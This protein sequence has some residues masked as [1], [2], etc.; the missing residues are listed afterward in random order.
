M[1][2]LSKPIRKSK[3]RK[4]RSM[5][6][7]SWPFAHLPDRCFLTCRQCDGCVHKLMTVK[8]ARVLMEFQDNA[9][10]QGKSRETRFFVAL[11]MIGTERAITSCH[12]NDEHVFNK[13]TM[14]WQ[15]K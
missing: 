4:S 9:R 6:S 5:R 13:M 3:A 11:A 2:E 14:C 12:W 15:R 10:R 1:E 7:Q 8:H